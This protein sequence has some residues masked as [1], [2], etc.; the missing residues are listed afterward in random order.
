[1]TFKPF[2]GCDPSQRVPPCII[3]IFGATGDLT[4]RK[5]IPSIYQ[6]YLHSCLPENFACVG[7]ARREK[8]H[9]IFR[10]EMRQAIETN[11]PDFDKESFESFAKKLFYHRAHFDDE[12]GYQKLKSFLCEIDEQYKTAKNR[13]FYL[14]TPPS[15]F[16]IICENLQ[17]ANLL[18]EKGEQWSR[19]II[20]K[21]F[22]RD[23]QSAKALNEQL[24][25]CLRERQIFRIDHYLGKETVQ[26]LLVFRF[27]NSIFEPLWNQNNIEQ[28]QITASEDLGIGTRGNFF[29]ETGLL[30]DIMQN[31][32]LQL[33]AL[34]GMEAPASLEADDIRNE[35]VKVLKSLRPIESMQKQC[36]RAQYTAAKLK[37]GEKALS[38]REEN[39]VDPKSLTETFLAIEAYI[40]NWRW[41]GVP[42]YLRAGKRLAK[43]VTEIAIY[44]KKPPA[45][46]FEQSGQNILV[47]RIQ[48]DAKISLNMLCKVPQMTQNI[49]PVEMNFDY[50]S[51]FGLEGPD[52]YEKLIQDCMNGDRTLFTRGDEVLEAWRF[53]NPILEAW[54]REQEILFYPSGTWGPLEAKELTQKNGHDWREF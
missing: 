45:P 38:Y 41:A 16:P 29:E 39:F 25:G 5:L 8:N 17:R 53:I 33:L 35:K 15:H 48:P 30:R 49:L 54:K 12:E 6:L 2:Q 32:L 21:P 43:R 4:A 20:E 47:I 46:L 50:Q 14:S 19:M 27:A 24:L 42:F 44:F 23:L 18:Q 52:A 34:V 51:T 1:M 37:D 26:N 10:Q 28:V 9:D 11:C 13:I 31:H 22:G 36:I 3:V 40:D 7:F